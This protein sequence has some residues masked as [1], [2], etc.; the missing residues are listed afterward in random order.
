MVARG[1]WRR[2]FVCQKRI[3]ELEILKLTDGEFERSCCSPSLRCIRALLL[4]RLLVRAGHVFLRPTVV[5][6]ESCS[7]RRNVG[8]PAAIGTIVYTNT[9]L[10]GFIRIALDGGVEPLR[11][12]LHLHS[13]SITGAVLGT[14]SS[15]V[16]LSAVGFC[17]TSFFIA[18]VSVTPGT[19][20]YFQ[21][22]VR[23]RKRTGV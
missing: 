8:W 10:V 2:V 7:G 14:S 15:P 21:P 11:F 12:I 1:L 23:K 19:T 9:H 5:R 16:S 17:G 20:Y 4:N 3:F 22:V 13:D 6:R 18:P